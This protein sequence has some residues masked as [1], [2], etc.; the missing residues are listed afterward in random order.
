MSNIYVWPW[1]RKVW[2]TANETLLLWVDWLDFY[3]YTNICRNYFWYD[4]SDD[5]FPFTITDDGVYANTVPMKI[6]VPLNV[7]EKMF[8]LSTEK[9]NVYLF[10]FLYMKRQRSDTS[11]FAWGKISNPENLNITKFQSERRGPGDKLRL[12]LSNN[13][14]TKRR[15]ENPVK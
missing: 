3:F 12:H 14:F 11:F 9:V 1:Y 13:V 15:I 4:C 5:V 2:M 10:D 8:D 7:E 6:I